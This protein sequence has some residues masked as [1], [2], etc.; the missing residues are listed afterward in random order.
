MRIARAN[1]L[2]AAVLALVVAGLI[3]WLI[4][5]RAAAMRADAEQRILLVEIND[6]TLQELGRWPFDRAVHA[7]VIERLRSAGASVVIYNIIFWPVGVSDESLR[8]VLSSKGSPV[9]F[10]N[11]NDRFQPFLLLPSVYFGHP[12]A[13]PGTEEVS[14]IALRNGKGKWP[15][16]IALAAC[17]TL[18]L[19]PCSPRDTTVQLYAPNRPFV[20]TQFQG[21]LK[22]PETTLASQVKDKIVIVGAARAS[23]LSVRTTEPEF[24]ARGLATLLAE[25]R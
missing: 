1:L 4:D 9:I 10:L 16:A 22:A 23:G 25:W 8:Q 13:D 17:A 2:T 3:A 14:R 7:K 18:R 19:D 15:H 21:I 24:T 20:R 5:H 12:Y 6:S 11:D